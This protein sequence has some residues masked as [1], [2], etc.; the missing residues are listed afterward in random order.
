[1]ELVSALTATAGS[2]F[3]ILMTRDDLRHDLVEWIR[4]FENKLH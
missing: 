2:M 3:V 4:A 1:M